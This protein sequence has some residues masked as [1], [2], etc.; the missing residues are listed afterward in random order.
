[1]NENHDSGAS[2]TTANPVEAPEPADQAS[3]ADKPASTLDDL[4]SLLSEFEASTTKPAEAKDAPKGQSKPQE[5]L[6][7]VA[8]ALRDGFKVDELR[9]GLRTQG[10]VV[11][12]LF[13]E[14]IRQQNERDFSRITEIGNQRLKDAGI[15]VGEDFVERWF[16]AEANM[17]PQLRDAFDKRYEFAQHRRQYEKLADKAMG[18]LMK[19]ARSQPDPEVT[20]D[21]M[22]VVAALKG[23]SSS[24]APPDPPVRYGDLTDGQFAAEKKKLGL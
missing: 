2:F 7:P 5:T 13:Q 19:S 9:H 18:R 3:A 8:A 1:M 15:P 4:T 14:Q 6:D 20:A 12:R 16:A 22:A 10:E 21:K 11:N 17:N 24:Q 23:A